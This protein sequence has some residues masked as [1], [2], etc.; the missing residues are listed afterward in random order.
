MKAFIQTLTFINGVFRF[1]LQ[2]EQIYIP[3]Y[4]SSTGS[5]F[6]IPRLLWTN[7][8]GRLLVSCLNKRV[9]L[10]TTH[11]IYKSIA[12]YLQNF[13]LSFG[14]H[15]REVHWVFE[16]PITKLAYPSDYVIHW[17]QIGS[18]NLRTYTLLRHLIQIWWKCLPTS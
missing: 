15:L 13:W 12:S 8:C 5:I 1:L 17:F 6:G 18:K 2:F 7:C 10:G 14:F 16:L 9:T 3:T 4:Y 11:G